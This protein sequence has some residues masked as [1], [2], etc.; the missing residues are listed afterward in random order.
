MRSIG[1]TPDKEQVKAMIRQMDSSGKGFVTT[2]EFMEIVKEKEVSLLFHSQPVKDIK[3]EI[4]R[5]FKQISTENTGKISF[6]ELK[7]AVNEI[8]ENI[9][10]SEIQEMIS[11][12]D[13]D[14]DGRIS[15]EEFLRVMYKAQS[16]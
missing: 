4:S 9:P 16:L 6:A 3:E 5:A 14:G 1:F 15:M 12:A 11:E 10:D 2:T 8:G 13:R 7:K